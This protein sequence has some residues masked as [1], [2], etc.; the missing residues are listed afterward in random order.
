MILYSVLFWTREQKQLLDSFQEGRST[1]ILG[2]YGSGKTLILLA[3]AEKLQKTGRDLVYINALDHVDAT[4]DH[5]HHKTCEDV[6]DVVVKFRFGSAV[7][8]MGTLR[9][10][11]GILVLP[12]LWQGR[13]EGDLKG[14]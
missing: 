13:E 10:D 7:I 1:V 5:K 3:L 9:R 4:E 8:D 14:I 2:D 11:K 12:L 6:L